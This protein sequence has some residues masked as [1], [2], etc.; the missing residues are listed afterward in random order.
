MAVVTVYASL[1]IV[2]FTAVYML[3]LQIAVL[4]GELS[5]V[6]TE[7]A[8]VDEQLAEQV[9]TPPSIIQLRSCYVCKTLKAAVTLQELLHR[10]VHMRVYDPRFLIRSVHTKTLCF[11]DLQ[12]CIRRLL[13]CCRHSV[14]KSWLLS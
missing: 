2:N 12:G 9:H 5:C 7:K 4:E 8:S 1:K 11:R 14:L 6:S 3:T 13:C 10:T